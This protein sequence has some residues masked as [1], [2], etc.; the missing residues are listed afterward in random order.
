MTLGTLLFALNE[1]D[2]W[3]CSLTISLHDR[4]SKAW[5]FVGNKIGKIQLYYQFV[6]QYYNPLLK[7]N[8]IQ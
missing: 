8:F 6:L 2:N 5:E 3:H 7:F 4:A 1:E